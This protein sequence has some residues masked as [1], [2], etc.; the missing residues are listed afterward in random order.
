MLKVVTL[1]ISQAYERLHGLVQGGAAEDG[2]GGQQ[3][4]QQPHV[5]DPWPQVETPGGGGEEG[6]EENSGQTEERTRQGED[7][8]VFYY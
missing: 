2:G 1:S 3:P 4:E 8:S 6:L 5:Q 7:F